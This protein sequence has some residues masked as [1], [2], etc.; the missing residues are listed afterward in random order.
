MP[1]YSSKRPTRPEQSPKPNAVNAADFNFEN[2]QSKSSGRGGARRN[3][4]R[5]RG[6]ATTKTRAIADKAA[7]EGLTPLEIMLAAMRELHAKGDLINAARVAKD[8]A[9]FV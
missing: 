4:G 3:A 2:N 9:P 5:K 8:A 1:T 7:A 6:S